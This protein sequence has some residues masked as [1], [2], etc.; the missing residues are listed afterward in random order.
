MSEGG[1]GRQENAASEVGDIGS[2]QAPAGVGADGSTLASTGDAPAA[3]A[4]AWQQ[5]RQNR[6]QGAG[7]RRNRRR[8]IE[9]RVGKKTMKNRHRTVEDRRRRR[10]GGRHASAT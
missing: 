1:A 8:T 5:N 10:G 6:R 7:R 9:D 3:A 2:D 4:K